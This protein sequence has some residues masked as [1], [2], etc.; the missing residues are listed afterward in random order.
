MVE[1]RRQ[2]EP[3]VDLDR[4]GHAL[5]AL[6]AV[7]GSGEVVGGTLEGQ[8]YRDGLRLPERI[9]AAAVLERVVVRCAATVCRFVVGFNH[10]LVC[11]CVEDYNKKLKL[12]KF[13]M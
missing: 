13:K 1:D 2:P 9:A 12:I 7:A 6:L 3:L 5:L 11:A 4:E 10:R 8:R